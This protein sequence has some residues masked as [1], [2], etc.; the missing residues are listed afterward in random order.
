MSESPVLPRWL[1]DMNSPVLPA[2]PERQS[3]LPHLTQRA[4][5]IAHGL[6]VDLIVCLYNEERSAADGSVLAET[7]FSSDLPIAPIGSIASKPMMW[8]LGSR[9]SPSN[10]EPA[11]LKRAIGTN[12]VLHVSPTN[13]LIEQSSVHLDGLTFRHASNTSLPRTSSRCRVELTPSTSAFTK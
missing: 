2:S 6:G 10:M 13:H 4:S 7:L 1:I 12:H 3:Q 11:G 9:H 5:R 8:F